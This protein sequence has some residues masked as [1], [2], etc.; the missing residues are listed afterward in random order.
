MHW[1]EIVSTT[2][3]SKTEILSQTIWN[4]KVITTDKKMVYLPHWHR[5]GIEQI[6][7]LF[8]EHDN[9]FQPFLSLSNKY[10][11]NFYNIVTL[12]TISWPYIHDPPKL[13]EAPPR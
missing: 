4:N 8:D 7:D 11:L 12:F 6:S 5:A 3:H 10:T 13:E 2:P 9:C 1:Q